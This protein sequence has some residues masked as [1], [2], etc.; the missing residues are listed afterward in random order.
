MMV[1]SIDLQGGNAVQL[2]GGRELRLDAGDPRPIADRFGRVGEI[3]VIDLD[4]AMGTGSNREVI[5]DLVGR[6]RCRVGG[7]IRDV[8]SAL[9]WLDAGAETAHWPGWMPGQRR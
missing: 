1:P 5:R 4:A 6:A 2:E 9:A 7:G 8:D 3:A